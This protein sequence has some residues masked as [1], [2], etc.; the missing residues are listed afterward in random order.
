MQNNNAL[1]PYLFFDGRCEEA[2]EFYRKTLGAE[3][4]MMARYKDMPPQEKAENCGPSMDGNKL[5]HA[6]VRIGAATVLMADGPGGGKFDGFALS[7]TVASPTE[8][9]PLFAA[10]SEGGKVDMP[11]GKTFFSPAFGMLTDRF[12]IKW[13]VYV[14]PKGATH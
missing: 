6:R 2:I 4:I 12:G 13:M 11:M 1:N 9:E 10:L 3:P 5:M 7:L 14:E 8:A